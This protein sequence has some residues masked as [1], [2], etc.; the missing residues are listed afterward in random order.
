MRED[1]MEK[2]QMIGNLVAV[3]HCSLGRLSIIYQKMLH[4]ELPVA[5][6]YAQQQ[7]RGPRNI[8]YC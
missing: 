4:L 5:E 1:L 8:G 2:K 7:G 6:N 3:D